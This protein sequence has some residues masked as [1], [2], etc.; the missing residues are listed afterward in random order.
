MGF[1]HRSKAAH[2][3]LAV[4]SV[5]T[6]HDR[7]T[8][9]GHNNPPEGRNVDI[10]GRNRGRTQTGPTPYP[11]QQAPDEETRQLAKQY[12]K[13]IQAIHHKNIIDKAILTQSPPKGMTKQVQKLSACIKPSSPTEETRV[14]VTKNTET[15][16]HNSMT[17]LQD[18]YLNIILI[19]NNLP[20]NETALQIAIG[21][22][23]KCY[24]AR[25]TQPTIQAARSLV[26]GSSEP[27]QVSDSL[28]PSPV[29]SL[30]GGTPPGLNLGSKEEFPPLP[31]PQ[32]TL[33][34]HSARSLQ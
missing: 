30:V 15:W 14:A 25:L 33:A 28:P 26:E 11:L 8:S 13:L 18:H 21:W 20:L 3:S 9:R 17:I 31:K 32:I 34:E 12:F 6:Q 5:A 4:R 16:L 7:D 22:A 27:S 2:S 24:K 23:R 1:P 10:R 29:G 19:Y